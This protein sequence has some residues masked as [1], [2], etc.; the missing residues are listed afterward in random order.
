[1]KFYSLE[2]IKR[3]K[4]SSKI[5]IIFKDGE[6]TFYGTA[7]ILENN[8]AFIKFSIDSSLFNQSFFLFSY[9]NDLHVF[10]NNN[11]KCVKFFTRNYKNKF[12]YIN[13]E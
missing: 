8:N 12:Q 3:F 10:E 11:L 1:M 4:E 9:K 6:K 5:P 2:Q 13:Q 7:H